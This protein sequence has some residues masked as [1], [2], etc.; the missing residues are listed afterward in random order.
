M[1]EPFSARTR[2]IAWLSLCTA[3]A[4]A[5]AYSEDAWPGLVR[6]LLELRAPAAEWRQLAPFRESPPPDNAPLEFISAWWREDNP[7]AEQLTPSQAVRQR[8]LRAVKEYPPDLPHLLDRLPQTLEARS[9]VEQLQREHAERLP[10]HWERAV[11]YWLDKT[12]PR[13]A[14]SDDDLLEAAR[15]AHSA[16][17]IIEG[18]SA[19]R[20]II[21][22]DR[23]KARPL[24][25]ELTDSTDPGVAALALVVLYEDSLRLGSPDAE[26]K[27]YRPAGDRKRS[28]PASYCE[29]RSRTGTGRD[30]LGRVRK[31]VGRV[32]LRR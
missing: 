18:E 10:D 24:L 21:H 7:V 6:D 15:R 22:R 30:T 17:G 28:W 8:L 27:R 29:R 25:E 2:A 23:G 11:E 9:V 31:L 13:A 12:S 20:G 4:P 14:R 1:V 19:I 16:K 3:A 5:A 32:V 26:A